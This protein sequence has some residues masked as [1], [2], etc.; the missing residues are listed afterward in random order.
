MLTITAI[1]DQYAFL[2]ANLPV[3]EGK[4]DLVISAD[5]GANGIK[6]E[7]DGT[8]GVYVHG[9]ENPQDWTEDFDHFALAV[10]HPKLGQIHPGFLSGALLIKSQID[11]FAG[12][13]PIAYYGHSYGAGRSSV[14]AGLRLTEGLPVARVVLFGEPMA[15]GPKLSEI[16]AS[17][18][19]ESYRNA[20]A[21]GHDF[22]TDVPFRFMP[23]NPYQ[24]LKA[25]RVDCHHSPSPND[26]W[27]LFKYHHLKNYCYAFG[28]GGAAPLS[29]YAVTP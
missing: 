13:R 8:V 9:S 26:P 15:G 24:P 6:V 29:L 17:V 1:L 23:D 10:N 12:S 27:L 28:C 19:V 14:L 7:D 25:P 18:S 21:N 2:Y 20:D 16:V 5:G 11:A 3:P 4:W 22:V